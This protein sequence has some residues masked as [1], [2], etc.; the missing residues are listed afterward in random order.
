MESTDWHQQQRIFCV[1]AGKPGTFPFLC[2]RKKERCVSHQKEAFLSLS[3]STCAHSHCGDYCSSSFPSQVL[4]TLRELFPF[5]LTTA[6]LSPLLC[7]GLQMEH[8]RIPISKALAAFWER[9]RDPNIEK[10][11]FPVLV[12]S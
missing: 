12:A 2:W 4:L 10:T 6:V 1:F 5:P 9:G 8:L 11:K 7:P 3:D